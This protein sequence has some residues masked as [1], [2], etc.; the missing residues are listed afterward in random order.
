[1]MMQGNLG[2][3]FGFVDLLWHYFLLKKLA[4]NSGG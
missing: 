3:V 4:K 1:M 2:D